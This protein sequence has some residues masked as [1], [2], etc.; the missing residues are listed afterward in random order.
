MNCMCLRLPRIFTPYQS[1]L[2]SSLRIVQ[3]PA[4]RPKSSS[5]HCTGDLCARKRNERNDYFSSSAPR[6]LQQDA[7][8]EKPP[9]K[10]EETPQNNKRKTTRSQPAKNSLRRVAVEAQRSR[11]GKDSKK[12]A[13]AAHQATSKVGHSQRVFDN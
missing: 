2:F 1:R 8:P 3:S 4:L 12:T 6:F 9:A 5:F 13:A 7:K 10:S 11:E